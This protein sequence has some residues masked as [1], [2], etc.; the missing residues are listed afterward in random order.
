MNFTI[1]RHLLLTNITPVVRAIS[2]RPQ[3]P[4]LSGIK[5]DV[6]K[7]YITLTAS[8][9]EFSI[10]SRVGATERLLTIQEEGR[11]VL[12]G[13]YLYEI[14]RKAESETID[15]LSYESNSVKVIADRSHF[16][17]NVIDSNAFPPISF[18]ESELNLTIDTLNLKQIIKKTAFATSQVMNHPILTGVCFETE[19]NKLT[20]TATDSYRLAEKYME[21][22]HEYPTLKVVIPA[23]SLEE[24]NKIIEDVNEPVEIHILTTKVL[25]KYKNYL[26]QTRLLEGT[27]PNTKSSMPT[28]FVSEITFERN[29]FLS[30]LDR[31]GLLIPQ[32]DDEGIIK[33]EIIDDKFV[34]IS[35]TFKEIGEVVEK[36]EFTSEKPVQ[37]MIIAYRY[38]YF[39]E[40]LKAIDSETLTL[41]LVSAMASSAITAKYDINYTQIVLP[42]TF[43]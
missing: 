20:T 29:S 22:D 32:Q 33:L 27:Y 4:A 43:N 6:R 1:N 34:E 38:K 13:K 5:I 16:S 26:F 42:V 25:F 39:V 31:V 12:P 14:V 11:V 9:G 23:K 21:F 35:A 30:T 7:D 40:A 24:L 19:G 2:S 15:F 17:L 3:M 28:K 37:R 10:Q 18:E 8:N 41:K 36:I